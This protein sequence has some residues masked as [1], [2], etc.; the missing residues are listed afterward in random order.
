[1]R[2]GRDD[3]RDDPKIASISEARK[4]AEAARRAAAREQSG[5]RRTIGQWI[6]GG[7]IVA[8]ALGMIIW[9]GRAMFQSLSFAP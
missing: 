4:R 5:P 1:M 7:V 6:T 8:M 9:W 3:H 2:N